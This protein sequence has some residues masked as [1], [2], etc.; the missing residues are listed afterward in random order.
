MMRH[1]FFILAGIFMVLT[2]CFRDDLENIKVPTWNPDVAVPLVNSQFTLED[3]ISGYKN[4]GSLVTDSSGFITLIINRDR[5]F[6]IPA[7]EFFQ[8]PDQNFSSTNAIQFVEFE[9]PNGELIH[10]IEV[11]EGFLVL[12]ASNGKD[13]DIH[14]TITIPKAKINDVPLEQHLLLHAAVNLTD[15]LDLSGFILDLTGDG[16]DTNTLE[17][18]YSAITVA[19]SLP[20]ILEKF[21]GSL[22]NLA[23][24]Y[25]EGFFGVKNFEID[26]DTISLQFLKNWVDGTIYITNPEIGITL[27]N[28][29]GI[30]FFLELS[31]FQGENSSF[32]LPI[33]GSVF[34][35]G[36]TVNFPQ[37]SLGGSTAITDVT[38]DPGNSNID[39][40]IAFSPNKITYRMLLSMNSSLGN[41]PVSNLRDTSEIYADVHLKIPF[42]GRIDNLVLQDTFDLDIDAIKELTSANFKLTASNTFPVNAQL[43]VFFA[44]TDVQFIDSLLTAPEN[45][46]AAGVINPNGEVVRPTTQ[47]TFIP[48]EQGKLQNLFTARKLVVR[49]R[50]SMGNTQQPS[51]KLLSSYRIDLNLGVV[52]GIKRK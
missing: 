13:E 44:D 7:S 17:I 16:S 22:Q 4:D 46:I 32:S 11:K 52:A 39:N 35:D 20:V 12:H 9:F 51:V 23:F 14:L 49:A 42:Q 25:A 38:I 10:K 31:N 28:D 24:S 30:P 33:S 3:I 34:T 47:T 1:S 37:D 45:I 41:V 50:L 5:I 48:F 27:N 26:T 19:D 18:Q 21:S 29:F 6:S 15:T 8:V 36:F 43:Q 2:S 40:I